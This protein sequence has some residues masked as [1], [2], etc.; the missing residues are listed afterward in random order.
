[1]ADNEAPSATRTHWQLVYETKLPDRCSWYQATP[2]RSLQ[3][4]DATRAKRG[5]AIIDVGGGASTLVDHLLE[6][7]FTDLSVL[8]VVN[9]PLAASR[10]RLGPKSSSVKWI[11]SDVLAWSPQRRYDVWHDRAAF[12]FLVTAADQQRYV[13][14]LREALAPGGHVIIGTFARQG[15]DRCSGLPVQRYDANSLGAVLG[16][17][18]QLVRG[19]EDRH[20]TPTGDVQQFFFGV[21]RFNP[22][23]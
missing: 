15:P 18:F 14:V 16:P 17:Q 1:M 22:G 12:H 4:I 13:E 7:G 3:C 9:P 8:D 2:T 23:P 5:A 21:W 20:V 10:D 19:A 11:V 6:L